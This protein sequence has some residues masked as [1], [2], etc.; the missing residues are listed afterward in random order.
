[1]AGAGYEDNRNAEFVLK[2]GD[3]Y[4]S[5]E[6]IDFKVAQG[7]CDKGWRYNLHSNLLGGHHIYRHNQEKN[8]FLTHKKYETTLKQW[9]EKEENKDNWCPI[10]RKWDVYRPKEE[11]RQIIQG[12]LCAV[13]E[14][15]F[16]NYFHGLL[17]HPEN[18][19][20]HD[21]KSVIGGDCKEA[22]HIFLTYANVNKNTDFGGPTKEDDMFAL[23]HVI[24]N[25]ILKDSPSH[26]PK[27]LQELHELLSNS[28]NWKFIVNHPS[29]WHWKSRYSYLERVWMQYLHADQN[30]QIIM[31]QKFREIPVK[32][33]EVDICFDRL[34]DQMFKRENGKRAYG[35][36]TKE[37]L[38][39]LRNV[40]VHYK[41][42]V[43]KMRNMPSNYFEKQFIEH[44]T[45][46]VS[47]LFLV[48]L[49]KK[50]CEL[51]IEI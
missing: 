5:S 44:I 24:F 3:P 33:W 14:C 22:K 50:M 27:D 13:H 43:E 18:I 48:N 1:M 51:K 30:T 23:S 26:Y 20:I 16:K 6:H 25:Q 39:Y 37:L 42:N 36:S 7:F 9:L 41:E 2:C 4:S 17:Y 31:V 21:D 38:R 19:L 47:E 45:T 34:L 15:H 49:Y 10:Y 11:A 12:I 28:D 29:M 8:F 35:L 46:E 32:G 40:R